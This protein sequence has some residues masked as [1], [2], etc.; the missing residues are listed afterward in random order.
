M[1]ESSSKRRLSTPS[2]AVPEG[3]WDVLPAQA[4][5][6]RNFE[7]R[8]RIA[9]EQCSY[10]EVIC[11]TFEFYDNLA[12]E[13]GAVIEG[14]MV[15][16]MGSDGRL[17]ALRPE[18]TTAIARIVAQRLDPADEPHRLF[19]IANV[20]REHSSRQ[21]QPRE[22]WQAGVERVGGGTA[23][24]DAEVVSLFI[25]TLSTSGLSDFQIGLGQIDF[26][27]CILSEL[28]LSGPDRTRLS[29]ALAARSLVEYERIVRGAGLGD[30]VIRK[31]LALPGLQGGAEVLEKAAE[32]VMG[33]GSEAALANLRNVYKCL[34]TAGY[35]ERVI[36]DLG[37]IRDYAYYTGMI[38][39]AYTPALGVPLGGGGRYDTLLAEFGYDAPAAGFALGIERIE[40][41]L[42]R[43]GG[44]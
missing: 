26:I 40:R 11:P 30:E 1:K 13:T 35:D 39:E 18:M 2:P 15:R 25:E 6:R 24:D 14:D 7:A 27:R 34:Q 41:A 32:L 16:F 3:L 36:L 9:F 17:L 42:A 21:G 22:F 33:D 37:I 43:S 5:Q 4:K 28:P 12:V 20:F 44:S 10:G 31:L 8:L 19:Y 23:A 29:A 38:F